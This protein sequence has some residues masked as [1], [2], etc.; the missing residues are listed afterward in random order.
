MKK[1]LLDVLKALCLWLACGLITQLFNMFFGWMMLS[2]P[3][4]LI[5]VFS[6]IWGFTFLGV[7]TATAS[8]TGV[9]SA[10]TI[11][12]VILSTMATISSLVLAIKNLW[13]IPA[14]NNVDIDGWIRYMCIYGSLFYLIM[15]VVLTW[16]FIVSYIETV[17]EKE[18][19]S[20]E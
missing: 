13:L 3:H 5:V 11:V 18:N 8:V 17:R 10:K 12:G 4:W 15:F 14:D 16:A 6:V 1:Y 7:G 19:I 9:F 20:H 2:W